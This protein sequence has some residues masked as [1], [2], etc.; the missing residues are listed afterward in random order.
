M[1]SIKSAGG[2]T[3]AES[4]ETAVIF[5]MPREAIESGSVDMVL[6]LEHFAFEI[7]RFSDRIRMEA[8]SSRI[9]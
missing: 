3:M 7:E 4:E 9:G 5:G 1:Q 2:L 8:D 6:R